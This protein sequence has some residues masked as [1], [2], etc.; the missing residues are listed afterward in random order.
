MPCTFGCVPHNKVGTAQLMMRLPDLNSQQAHGLLSLSLRL[1]QGSHTYLSV[2]GTND[3]V[4]V[5]GLSM[6]M[7]RFEPRPFHA[8][9][10]VDK[11]A[12]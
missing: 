9:L 1:C 12:L 5:T 8:G 10:V 2:T 11:E 4:E 6:Q 7:V 3:L